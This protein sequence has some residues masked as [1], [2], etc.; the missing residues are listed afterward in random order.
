MYLTHY[1][2]KRKPFNISPDPLF[3][4]LGKRHQEA[5]ATL[6][7]GIIDNKGFLLLTG[8]IGTGKTVLLNHLIK[9]I[10]TD[11]T[12]AVIPDPELDLISFFNV[13]SD[14]FRLNKTIKQKGEFL[15]HFRN[16]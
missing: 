11:V 6:R 12:V 14:E 4:W 2:L 8:D 5:L 16:F 1:G 10:D 15:F 7:Y 3:L 13:L 9:L